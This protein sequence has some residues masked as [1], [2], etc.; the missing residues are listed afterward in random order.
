MSPCFERQPAWEYVHT[1][2]GSIPLTNNNGI[3]GVRH[4]LRP[5][6]FHTAGIN[7]SYRVVSL[8]PGLCHIH[9]TQF[10]VL[11]GDS[12]AACPLQ[13]GGRWVPVLLKIL[14][15]SPEFKQVQSP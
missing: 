4:H 8:C 14:G 5:A 3:S 7:N 2:L 6:N 11:E 12:V 13:Q 10:K 9:L 15:P 1:C